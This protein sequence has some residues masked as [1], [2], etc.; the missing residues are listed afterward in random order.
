[1]VGDRSGLTET[2]SPLPPEQEALPPSDNSLAEQLRGFGPLGILAILIVVAGS[3]VSTAV[4]AMLVLLWVWLS[5]TPWRE[6]G[7]VRPRNWL[8]TVVLGVVAGSAFKLLMKIIVMPLLGADPINRAFHYLVVT[9]AAVPGFLLA[10]VVGAGWGEETFFRG[11]AFE[12]LG[13]LFG[14]GLP[15]KMAIVI[16]TSVGFGLAHYAVQG[17]HGTEQAT[18]T[19]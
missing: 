5:R 1:M 17:I 18:I 3:V 11:Y 8:S 19:G 10:I 15:A 6:I 14:R 7:Y 16:L 2:P 9:R 13:K 4:S 12:R